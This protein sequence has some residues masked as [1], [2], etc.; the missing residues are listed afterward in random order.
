MNN[1]SLRKTNIFMRNILLRI[2]YNKKHSLKGAWEDGG[3]GG[4]GAHPVP[5][6]N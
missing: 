6:F 3:V 2:L 5:R 4:P 1:I